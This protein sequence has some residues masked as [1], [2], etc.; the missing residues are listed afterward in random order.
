M[1]WDA[2]VTMNDAV[3]AVQMKAVVVVVDFDV[4]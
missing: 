1:A 2:L 3:V 4:G